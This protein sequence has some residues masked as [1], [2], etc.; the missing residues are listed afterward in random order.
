MDVV[1]REQVLR[2]LWAAVLEQDDVKSQDNFFDLGGHSI[3]AMK[4]VAAARQRG[5]TITLN[6]IFECDT[7]ADLAAVAE[8]AAG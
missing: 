1:R 3:G 7:L 8:A 6:Q 2:E 4:L 5:L